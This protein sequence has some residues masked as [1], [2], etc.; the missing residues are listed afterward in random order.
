MEHNRSIPGSKNIVCL[1][2]KLKNLDKKRKWA[3]LCILAIESN[4]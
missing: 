2:K 1:P 4:Y 3:N